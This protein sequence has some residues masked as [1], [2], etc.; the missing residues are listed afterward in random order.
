MSSISVIQMKR[1]IQLSLPMAGSRFLQ[2]LSGFFATMMVSHLGKIVLA[3]CAFINSALAFVL[4]IFIS[5]VFS[6]SFIVGQSFGAKKYDEI[7]AFVQ[8]GMVLSS[9]LGVIMMI[10]FW[11]VD[12]ALKWFHENAQM[13]VYVT[14][15]FHALMW[16]AVPILLQ[17]CL[18]QFFYGILKQRLVIMINFLSMF[19]GVS[20]AYLLIFGKGGLPAL[21]V[22][23]LGLAFAIQAWFDFLLLLLCCCV[24]SDFKKFELFKKRSLQDFKYLKKIFSIGWPMSLQFGGELGAFFVM[25]MMIGWLGT[26]ALVVSQ[27]TQ[28]WM[29]LVVVPIFAMAEA[30]GILVGQA[31]GAKDFTE[32]NI[33]NRA[34]LFLALG[35][36]GILDV[37]F[38]FFPHFF[39]SFYMNSQDQHNPQLMELIQPMFALMAAALLFN[40]M[41][42]VISGSLRGL[43]D[44][45]FPMRVGLLI[46]WGL[47]LPL[48]YWFA[49]TL[50]WG[51][52][53]FRSGGNIGLLIG[54]LIL[55][56][57][58]VFKT[59]YTFAPDFVK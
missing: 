54:A 10:A 24:L 48:G 59:R 7:G 39:A 57:R 31:V 26:N 13:L 29:F 23:G 28:Q 33:I 51:V 5:I 1:V 16:G 8:Q 34:S 11:Y 20:T 2:M 21:G 37:G 19:V 40:S 45:K 32:L 25:T 47:V 9:M 42:D 12:D 15:Y 6:L 58:W 41:R 4:L 46:M 14:D 22:Y 18:E 43:F 38:I 50:H 3:A 27:V 17:S 30:S 56:R 53:G 36:I 44:T 49:F 35:L 55:Y 52:L